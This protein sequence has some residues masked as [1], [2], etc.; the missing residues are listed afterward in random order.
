MSDKYMI[1][2]WYVHGSNWASSGANLVRDWPAAHRDQLVC[3]VATPA[4]VGEQLAKQLT[5]REKDLGPATVAQQLV[6][7]ASLT[8]QL[9]QGSDCGQLSA[10]STA[11]T[12]ILVL[13]VVRERPNPGSPHLSSKDK[14]LLAV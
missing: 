12:Q 6:Y 5:G 8:E 10:W 11:G 13:T 1:F 4:E 3:T 14:Q 9:E 7:V 2:S